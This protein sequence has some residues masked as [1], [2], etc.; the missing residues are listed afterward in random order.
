MYYTEYRYGKIITQKKKV[1][2]IYYWKQWKPELC[3]K[4]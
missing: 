4:Q 2:K 3:W 1:F